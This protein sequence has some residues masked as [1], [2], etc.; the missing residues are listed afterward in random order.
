MANLNIAFSEKTEAEKIRIAKDFYHQF[1]D[2]FL[3][4]IKMLSISKN[5]LNKRFQGNYE[6][7]NDLFA[8]GQNVQLHGGHFF[9]W[10]YLNI[11]SAANL[12][13]PFIGIYMPLSNK[14]FDKLIHH[15]RGRFGTI[16]IAANQFRTTFHQYA[17]DRYV[18]ALGADQNPGNPR[19]AYWLSFF[20]QMTP[21][22][23]GPERGATTQNTAIVFIH[24]YP[25]KRGFY[26]AEL[27]LFTTDPRSL[28][29][30]EITKALR[31]FLETQ[32]RLR[33]ANYLWSHRRWKWSY[34]AEKHKSL[35]IE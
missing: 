19:G 3:E 8:S 28:T 25:V 11:A 14:L 21:F 2:N 20:G 12:K 5:E 30:G 23:I 17:N 9:N 15:L 32:I 13:Y 29:K 7:V 18:L 6:V 34:D 31:D 27:T 33:P 16:Q 1:V 22:V 24:S 4:T 35:T 10:E 26:K